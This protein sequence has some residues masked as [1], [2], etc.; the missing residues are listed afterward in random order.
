MEAYSHAATKGTL[1]DARS[2]KGIEIDQEM[3]GKVVSLIATHS[4]GRAGGKSALVTVNDEH[5][6]MAQK[7]E[8]MS[9]AASMPFDIKCFRDFDEALAWVKSD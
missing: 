8:S 5:F 2:M 6:A 4:S 1:W 7:G 9:R 3:M